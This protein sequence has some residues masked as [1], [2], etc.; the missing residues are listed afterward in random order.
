MRCQGSGATHLE[1]H[2][3]SEFPRKRPRFG[4]TGSAPGTHKRGEA[5][6]WEHAA[7]MPRNVNCDVICET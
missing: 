1:S 4:G 2:R 7:E 6:V 3:R 5:V